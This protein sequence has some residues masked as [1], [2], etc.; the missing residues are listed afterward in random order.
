VK[1]FSYFY[2]S[3]GTKNFSTCVSK[4]CAST[5][6]STLIVGSI[7]LRPNELMVEMLFPWLKGY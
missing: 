5:P 2:I 7:E 3:Y 1:Y 6:L 4:T